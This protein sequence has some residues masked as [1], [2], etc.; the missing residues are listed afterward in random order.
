MNVYEYGFVVLVL[1]MILI[2]LVAPYINGRPPNVNVNDL[3]EE[4]RMRDVATDIGAY[5]P[6]YGYVPATVPL[7]NRFR[8][9]QPYYHRMMT[10]YPYYDPYYDPPL[11]NRPYCLRNPGCRPCPNWRWMQSPNCPY[12]MK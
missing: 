10:N 6:L 4:G 11:P 12:M 9:H 1:C 7:P 5:P 8:Y 3:V 2:F